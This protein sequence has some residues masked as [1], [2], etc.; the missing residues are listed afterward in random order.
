[1]NSKILKLFL[2]INLLTTVIFADVVLEKEK[3][4]IKLLGVPFYEDKTGEL[5]LEEV[6]QREFS[7]NAGKTASF[8]FTSSVYWFKI[9]VMAKEDADLHKW[10]LHVAYSLLDKLDLYVCDKNDN[11]IELKKSGKM[12]PYKERELKTQDFIF[13]IDSL[14]EQNLYLRV[15]TQSSMQVPMQ[16]QTSENLIGDGRY[17]PVLS[18]I[19][20]GLFVLILLYNIT[21]FSYSP[22]RSYLFYIL[23]ISSFALWQL[24]LDGIGIVFFWSEW[25]WMINHGAGTLAGTMILSII[26]FSR[27]FLRTKEL[28]PKIDKVLCALFV[29]MIFVT[30]SATF[31][32]YSEIIPI[33]AATSVFLP[34]ILLAAGVIAYLKGFY[35]ARFYIVGWGFFLVG[36]VL[37]ALNKFSIIVGYS[38]LAYA[39]QVGSALEMIF[40][41]WAL[42]DLH[43]QSEREY[44]EKVNSINTLLQEEVE[45]NLVH[46]RQNDQVLIEKSRLAATGEMIEQIAHQWRQPLQ[47]LALLN[48]DLYFKDQFNQATSN[49][50]EKTHDKI[51]EQLQY[52]SKT[53][54]DFRNFS[55]PKKER[56]TFLIE[57]VILSALN[58]SEGSLQYA[59]IKSYLISK[60]ESKVYGIRQEIMQVFMNLIK[61]VQDIVMEKEVKAGWIKFYVAEKDDKI[62]IRVEDNAGGIE[63]EKIAKV[64]E[65]YFSTKEHLDSSG[66]G[67]YMS[68]E[69]I[70]KSMLGTIDVMN[71]KE[72]AVFTIILPKA[73]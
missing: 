13:K 4:N 1:M 62:E 18:G 10:W 27:T 12:R 60:N 23:F 42:A 51:N 72:G 9:H 70:E 43:K 7:S 36:S 11:L 38:F 61:N 49:D 63:K 31:R 34:F 21:S 69:I 14:P 25:Q 39:Q 28:S 41:S 53:I 33:A 67:L 32:P 54:D 52:M 29:V 24:N 64:F 68:R 55:K 45:K 26:A 40:L 59:K 16:I 56:E 3:Q 65:P 57:D 35:P 71:S 30:L 48:Q 47:T 22:N 2:L 6:Q 19:Y 46:I 20:Y 8:G 58:L 5:S 15:E 50:Y 44:L 66:I 37:F 17:L 73:G